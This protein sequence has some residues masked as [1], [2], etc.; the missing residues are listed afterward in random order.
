MSS[1]GDRFATIGIEQI[2][3]PK[4][5]PTPRFA[6]M[7]YESTATSAV[8][9]NEVIYHAHIFP[10]DTRQAD[11]HGE[12]KTPAQALANAALHW[13]RHGG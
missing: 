13:E 8:I 5:K 3:R 6:D 2:T 1:A 12:G 9:E 4:S 7:K 10:A 11:H